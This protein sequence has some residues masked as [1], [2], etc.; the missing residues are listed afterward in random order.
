MRSLELERRGTYSV[1]WRNKNTRNSVQISI[2]TQGIC[3]KGMQK[4]FKNRHTRQ[5]NTDGAKILSQCRED[6]QL[7]AT[8]F[9]IALMIC[10]TCF[11][12]L[13][14][15]HHELET[16]FMLLP[17]MAC[18]ALVVGGRL[19]QAWRQAMRQG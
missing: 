14:A 9:F 5:Q 11:G 10:S 16:I 17:N 18:N 19:L 6:N 2:Y 12:Q 3:F 13:Y 8:E 7:D 4:L 15:Y 1:S